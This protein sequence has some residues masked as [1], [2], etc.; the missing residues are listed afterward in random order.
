MNTKDLPR[1][2]ER[3]KNEIDNY[4]QTV[5][6]LVALKYFFENEFG[7]NVSVGRKMESR[8][9][10]QVTPDI[11][12]TFS[13]EYGLLCEI[14]KT[15]SPNEF[16]KIIDQVKKYDGDLKGWH[17]NDGYVS[18]ND[19]SVVCDITQSNELFKFLIEKL[20]NGELKLKHNFSIIEFA[21]RT[22]RVESIFLRKFPSKS[23][24]VNFGVLSNSDLDRIL[25]NSYSVSMER[26]LLDYALKDIK[27][28]DD[29]PKTVHLMQIL[30]DFVFPTLPTKKE[31]RE[32]RGRTI[33]PKRV[34]I[35]EIAD[36]VEKN[37]VFQRYDEKD[38]KIPRRR[39]ISKAMEKFVEIKLA[40]KM[41]EDG[42]YIIYYRNLRKGNLGTLDYLLMEIY[43]EKEQ[44][45]LED[46]PNS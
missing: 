2:I 33:M 18:N 5:N 21:R 27:L 17:T 40:T 45:K 42:N 38:P 44:K 29:A 30:W 26:T 41:D 8:G 6:C 36:L 35:G 31:Y 7:A 25:T 4:E 13:E 10:N 20:E 1:H 22:Q 28:Y 46:Y 11:I 23:E 16:D 12:S 37:Y 32:S 39:W 43:G 3:L 14:K 19:L 34:N 9:S 15:I 24:F